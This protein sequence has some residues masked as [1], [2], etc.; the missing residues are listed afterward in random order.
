MEQLRS[1]H[2]TEL[3]NLTRYLS[4]RSSAP[5][6]LLGYSWPTQ[7]QSEISQWQWSS[8]ARPWSNGNR[9]QHR[10]WLE[11]ATVTDSCGSQTAPQPLHVDQAGL[12]TA[13]TVGVRKF[14][15]QARVGSWNYQTV[16]DE[17]FWDELN[18][19]NSAFA[20]PDMTRAVIEIL[21]S[22]G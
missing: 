16:D 3:R 13:A 22:A 14:E 20:S 12:S 18:F 8:S 5:D 2:A 4:Q 17:I 10:W 6:E 11:T 15:D 21:S 9:A 7:L 1:M 19:V